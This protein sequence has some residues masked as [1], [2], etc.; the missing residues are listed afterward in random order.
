MTL[1][2]ALWLL[3]AFLGAVA[4]WMI[5]CL[6]IWHFVVVAAGLYEASTGSPLPGLGSVAGGWRAGST[7]C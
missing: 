3:L 5:V 6:G 2:R 4:W 7:L 1:A